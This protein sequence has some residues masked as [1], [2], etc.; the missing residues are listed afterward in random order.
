MT[1][2][3]RMFKDSLMR[4]EQ[5]FSTSLSNHGT[6]L[7]EQQRAVTA[8]G[9]NLSELQGEINRTNADL[10]ALT[11]RL[12]DLAELCENLEPLLSRLNRLLNGG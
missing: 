8:Q 10:Q 12:Q 7:A 2:L 3:E 9:Q 5:D 11:R 6:T 1:E 4:M